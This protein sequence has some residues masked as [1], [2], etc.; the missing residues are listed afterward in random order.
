MNGEIKITEKYERNGWPSISRPDLKPP[1]GWSLSLVTAVQRVRNHTLAPDGER[2]AF[3]WDRE[4]LSDIYRM[5]STGGWPA[6]ISTNRGLVAFWDDELPRW[7]P[8]S[9]W[10]AFTLEDHVHVARADGGLPRKISDFVPKASS[11]MWMPDS[12]GLIVTVERH[13]AEQL[14]LTDRI[15]AWPRSLTDDPNGDAWDA[16]PAADGHMVAYVYR[17]FDDLNRT[18]IR[19]I[20]LESGE[21][22]TIFSSPQEFNHTPR[23]SPS[24]EVIAFLSQRTG[25]YE[26]WIIRPDGQGQRQLTQ[27]GMDAA[28]IAWSPDGTRLACTV[29][30]GGAFELAVVDAASGVVTTLRSGMGFHAR[31]NWSP[32]GDFLTFEYE[33][34]TQ[35]PDLY[36]LD[37]ATR[38]VTQLT[39]SNPPALACLEQVVPQPVSY[40]SFD[41]LEIPAFLYRPA[42][43]NGAAIVNPHGGP[44]SQR[45]YDWDG[46]AQ[47]LIAKGYTYLAPNYRGS[48]GYGREF[49]HLN[50][51][52]W[53]VG[54]TQ[55]CLHGARFLRQLD[56]IDPER[57]AIFG[58]SYGGYL[59]ICCLSRDPE[60]LFACGIS[61]YGDSNLVSSWAQ[62]NRHLRLYTEVCLGHPGVNRQVYLDGSPIYQVENVRK[63]VLI[64][65]GLLDD[66]VPPQ[67]SE[68]WVEAL[69]RAGK[70]YEYKTYAD[71]PH[72]F[73]RRKNQL[74]AYGRIERFLDWYLLPGGSTGA[75]VT[76]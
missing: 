42:K 14:V 64:L 34:P 46:L 62:C 32:G 58:G 66:V 3:I 36:R 68:E 29:N 1:E 24:G 51:N 61:K 39:F 19:A 16:Q 15:G 30:R 47:Y 48:T 45:V 12:Q 52:D 50:H 60:Y 33:S 37:V 70:T 11:P 76:K 57:I 73:L 25:F 35:P 21:M 54:D 67:A 6:R 2:I 59:T 13:E 26:I 75:G 40:R 5:S 65:H 63:P 8:D 69:R 20:D 7:S 74:D 43:P 56:G 18:D 49:E 10:L 27:L 9:R 72:G 41:G 22:R 53:G 38:A 4:D 17:P 71:E 23:W 44:T 31:P 55:D 28:D